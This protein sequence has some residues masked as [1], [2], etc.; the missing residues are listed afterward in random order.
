MKPV[1]LVTL[2][3]IIV[4]V[5]VAGAAIA[6][7]D[8][9]RTRVSA[10][11]AVEAPVTTGSVRH[12]WTIRGRRTEV[13]ILRVTGIS[14][15]N[16]T[17]TV[18]C[19]GGGCPFRTK[20][21]RPSGGRA[22]LVRPFRDHRMHAGANLAIIIVAPGT[23]GRYLSF[24]MRPRAI[25]AIK[26]TCSAPGSLSP[27]G[28]PG[29]IGPQGAPGPQGPAGPQGSQGPVGATGDIGPSSGYFTK[30]D[31]EDITAGQSNPQ[32]VAQLSFLP[33]GNYLVFARA[34]VANFTTA[35]EGVR[36]LVTANG[37]PSPVSSIAVGTTSGFTSFGDLSVIAPV[38]AAAQ[39][40]LAFECY[41]DQVQGSDPYLEAIQ[42]SAV[43]LG[44]LD[45]R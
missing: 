26:A 42:L 20:S 34:T 24:D 5:C 27:I 43:R 4:A 19:D 41:H 45:I 15:A 3:A 7:N 1:R 40:N 29:P 31:H 18:L 22:N 6:R 32:E 11:A 12:S 2:A 25:P 28:C 36:C 17:I 44:S 33:A 16:A 38:N 23:T 9:S 14:P 35:G 21:I 39:F 8:L 10:Q 30:R 13:D 37:S